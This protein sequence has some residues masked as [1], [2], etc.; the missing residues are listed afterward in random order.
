MGYA[1]KKA[2]DWLLPLSYHRP[3][4]VARGDLLEVGNFAQF[5]EFL[6]IKG[7][8]FPDVFFY[9]FTSTYDPYKPRKVSWI[10]LCTFLRN[11]EDRQTRRQTDRCGNF[12]YIDFNK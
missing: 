5:S 2:R 11:L 6:P 8:N 3:A 12:T 1:P 7:R 4:C 10:S 9:P